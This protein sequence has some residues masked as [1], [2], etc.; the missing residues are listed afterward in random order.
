M[1]LA[2]ALNFGLLAAMTELQLFLVAWLLLRASERK[3]ADAAL[4]GFFLV[5]ALSTSAEALALLFPPAA[6][7]LTGLR[8]PLAFLLGPAFFLYVRALTAPR[9]AA[10]AQRI[11]RHLL[12]PALALLAMLPFL[13]LDEAGRNALISG[14]PVHAA[15][16]LRWGALALIA[17]LLIFPLVF[18]A[19]IVASL[20][21]LRGHLRRIQD[22]FSALHD[23]NLA[24]LRWT[25][26]ALAAAWLFDTAGTIAGV[27]FHRYVPADW[28]YGV[29][30]LGWL[31]ALGLLAL[32]QKPIYGDAA[33]APLVQDDAVAAAPGERKY[34][35]SALSDADLA[36][37][38][39]KLHAA[40]RGQRLYRNP[41]LTLRDLGDA[42][43]IAESYLSQTLNSRVGRNF[44]EYVNG[45]RIDE[46]RARLRDGDES[47]LR[48][49]TDVG[50]NSRST[51]NATFRKLTGVTPSAYRAVQRA[52]QRPQA[53]AGDIAEDATH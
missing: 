52:A 36:R 26:L 5:N 35:R 19:Y 14:R 18:G 22:F 4:A 16:A 51:F 3:D 45:W 13:L 50:F 29:L 32:R 20:G 7:L 46:A 2:D 44:Y 30:E 53:D 31:F 38:A 10:G 6:G 43:G 41:D 23:R 15:G 28:V 42:T 12:V 11:G 48:I 40:M 24:W 17:D 47:V 34:A 8:L 37:I 25:L 21:R 27:F 1:S 49:C 39:D 33:P 9:P